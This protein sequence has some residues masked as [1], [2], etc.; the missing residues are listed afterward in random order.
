MKRRIICVLL[1][2]L[3]AVGIGFAIP[4]AAE[5]GTEAE[6]EVTRSQW[7]QKLVSTFE[8][9]VEDGVYPDNYFSDLSSSSKYY[10]DMLL[11]VEFGVVD[12]PAGGEL[13]PD[14]PATREFAAQ[15]LNFCP[16]RRRCLPARAAHHL[17]GSRC[18]DRRCEGSAGCH[19]P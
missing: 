18:Y 13:R 1:V 16:D 6:I 14:D 12:I 9:T 5:T 2:L 3:L 8:M 4:M 19:R 15:T 17:C 7:L 11:A 10:Y